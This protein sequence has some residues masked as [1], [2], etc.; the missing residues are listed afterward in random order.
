MNN[1]NEFESFYD[2]QQISACERWRGRDGDGMKLEVA[3]EFRN[4]FCWLLL[5]G[6]PFIYSGS[7]LNWDAC[8]QRFSLFSKDP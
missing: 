5:Q 3:A 1:W 4:S 6:I 8:L 7:T 2:P